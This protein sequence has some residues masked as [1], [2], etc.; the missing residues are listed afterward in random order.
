M[1]NPSNYIDIKYG[2]VEARVLRED[3]LALLE[4]ILPNQVHQAPPP[5][6]EAQAP[7][8]PPPPVEAQAPQAP[9]PPVEAQAPQAPPPPVEAQAPQ[10]PPSPVEEEAPQAPPPPVE[11]EADQPANN[12]NRAELYSI[13][14]NCDPKYPNYIR[15]RL[16]RLVLQGNT[17]SKQFSEQDI[18][19]LV[20]LC[21][22][23]RRS[24][25]KLFP[26][27]NLDK[28]PKGNVM[29]KI[30]F[31]VYPERR[32]RHNLVNNNSARQTRER[33]NAARAQQNM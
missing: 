10:A 3:G 19:D 17:L 18:G 33:A 29:Q 24:F 21:Q 6:V 1:E 32:A 7:Q 28:K 31:R 8:A 9:P 5:P 11:E 20:L 12:V 23:D 2:G 27:L 26:L 16:E 15:K 14:E 22:L 4:R 13:L 25:V 30:N